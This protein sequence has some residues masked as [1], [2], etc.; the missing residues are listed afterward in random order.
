MSQEITV[1][2]TFLVLLDVFWNNFMLS[3]TKCLL[4]NKPLLNPLLTFICHLFEWRSSI[5]IFGTWLSL[6]CWWLFWRTW[7]WA[8]LINIYSFTWRSSQG[9]F[10]SFLFYLFYLK[11]KLEIS[12]NL[13]NNLCENNCRK[14]ILPNFQIFRT[15][16]EEKKIEPSP[17]NLL[18]SFEESSSEQTTQNI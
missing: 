8:T 15:K 13:L 1:L 6:W 7:F 18:S 12:N 10:T 5:T 14:T 4:R 11:F 9:L 17:K 16:K 3:K 2:I